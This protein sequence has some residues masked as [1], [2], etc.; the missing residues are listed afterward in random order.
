MSLFYFEIYATNLKLSLELLSN[1]IKSK[2]KLAKYACEDY[3]W[4]NKHCIEKH[5]FLNR[6]CP[7]FYISNFGKR[8]MEFSNLFINASDF[9]IQS[10]E[11]I[12]GTIHI[13]KTIK[14]ETKYA[15]K[16]INIE[17]DFDGNE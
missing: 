1:I 3:I 14:D 17:N 11:F 2:K 12:K 13:V 9:E 5:Q 4:S 7:G 8:L 16:I 15:A 6:I 10:N